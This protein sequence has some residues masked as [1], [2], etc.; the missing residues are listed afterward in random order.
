M[1]AHQTPPSLV[2]SREK[3][4]SGL[5]FPSPMHESEKWQWSRSVMP[6]SQRPH[7]LCSL[8]GSSIHGSFQARVLEWSATAFSVYWIYVLE[9]LHIS[10]Y[11]YLHSDVDRMAFPGGPRGEEPHCQCKRHKG[12]ELNPG[13]GR[14]PGVGKVNPL[15]YSCLENP[16]DRGAW[17]GYSPWCCRESDMTKWLRTA[18]HIYIPIHS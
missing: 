17:W 2:F 14:S 12:R 18:Q 1:A 16:K 11:M 4:W 10:T 3:Y 15:Q 8:P 13:L 6:D 9:N 5:P 7:G